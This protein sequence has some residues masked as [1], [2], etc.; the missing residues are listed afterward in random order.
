M[1]K[2]DKLL[3]TSSLGP[4]AVAFFIAVFVL[5]IQI[6]WLYIDEIAGKGVSVLIMLELVGY[7]S[8]SV[9]PM[10]LP[11]AVL[12]ASVM[13]MGG[14]AERYELSSMKSAGVPLIRVM[15]AM[16]LLAASISVFSYVCSDFLIP[17]ANLKFKSRLFD[18]R[19]QKPALSIEEGV[20]NEDFRQFVIRIGDKDP[21]G[22]TIG[23]VMI[24][25]QSNLGQVKFSQILADSGQMYTTGDKRFFVMNLFHGT[26]Y[27]EPGN[28][29]PGATKKR[30]PFIRTNFKSWSKVWDMRE[31][32]M[33]RT[34]EDRFS[35]QRTM[36]SMTQ[37]R[38]NVDSLQAK[39]NEAGQLAVNDML[40]NVKRQPI[41]PPA[42]TSTP[43]TINSAPNPPPKGLSKNLNNKLSNIGI[44][45][46]AASN[47]NNPQ[48][49][50]TSG[51]NLPVQ[52]LSKPLN[53]YTSLLETFRP[54]DR[55]SLMREAKT[56][57]GLSKNIVETRK[58]Q[59][60]ARRLDW[61]KTGYELYNKYSFALVCFI[62]LFIGAPMGAII[63]KGGFGYPIL[64]SIIFFVTFVFLAI[65]CRKLAE[66]YL[67]TPFWAAMTPCA[68]LAVFG[69]YVTRKAMNDSRLFSTEGLERFLFRLRL[70]KKQ[71]IALDAP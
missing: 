11:I 51:P 40:L 9:F 42:R 43:P 66:S 3:L 30:F 14:L 65:L 4:F 44:T 68:I 25:D 70:A 10:A 33:V 38:Q 50:S 45:G 28:Q 55:S 2:I 69:L 59:V 13:V 37:L 54:R 26:Q 61:V 48:R 24:E 5:V 60:T 12:I 64:V 58:N 16:I 56:R 32:E 19:K 71:K 23:E 1:K 63:G 15:R 18:I 53:Q 20:F 62:F 22:E 17:I 49:G 57:E 6:M 29:G 7:M 67:M 39:I 27:Q 46:Q 34:D 41:P 36:L 47:R 31:F 35:T 52:E 8:V 21:D